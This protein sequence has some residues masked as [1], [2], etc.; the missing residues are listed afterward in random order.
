MIDKVKRLVFCGKKTVT[1]EWLEE[2][3]N[4]FCL[5][6]AGAAIKESYEYFEQ[7]GHKRFYQS[8]EYGKKHPQEGKYVNAYKNVVI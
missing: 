2:N 4:T 3:N 8:C 5:V 6:C 7:I 1:K